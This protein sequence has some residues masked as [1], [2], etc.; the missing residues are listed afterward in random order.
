MGVCESSLPDWTQRGSYLLILR[1]N[2]CT[3]P[4]AVTAAKT[5][6]AKGDQATSPTTLFRSYVNIGSLER[7]GERQ[8]IS[9]STL[10]ITYVSILYTMFYKNDVCS[11]INFYAMCE[12]K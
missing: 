5:V 9:H 3:L 4:S 6:E 12:I 1:S 10:F 11:L 7:E 2:T 8:E